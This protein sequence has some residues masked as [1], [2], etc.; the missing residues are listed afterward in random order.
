MTTLKDRPPYN[1]QVGDLYRRRKVVDAVK[2]EVGGFRYDYDPATYEWMGFLEGILDNMYD[3]LLLL[4]SDGTVAFAN[5][6]FL[7]RTGYSEAEL[8]GQH[9]RLLLP[10]SKEPEYEKRLKSFFMSPDKRLEYEYQP[11]QIQY[12]N[13]TLEEVDVTFDMA[14]DTGMVVVSVRWENTE[15]PEPPEY[16]YDDLEMTSKEVDSMSDKKLNKQ[17]EVWSKGYK[18]LKRT[19][20]R[21]RLKALV[22]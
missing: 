1:L 17:I 3:G 20:W 22:R 4:K 9:V 7:D 6:T 14:R 5:A 11:F 12:S 10:N 13:G 16:D 2:D 15:E 8:I 21:R 19:R 18:K